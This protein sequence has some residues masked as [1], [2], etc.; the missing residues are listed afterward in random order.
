M[1]QSS[2]F[3]HTRPTQKQ[4]LLRFL[5]ARGKHG[6][7]NHEL[8]EHIGYRYGARIYE[9]RKEGYDIRR[10]HVKGTTWRFWLVDNREYG[11]VE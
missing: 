8:N 11:D 3:Q 4:K 10:E 6:L 9:L 5:T 2:L 7:T 1:I